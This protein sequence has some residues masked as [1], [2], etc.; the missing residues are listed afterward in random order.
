MAFDNLLIPMRPSDLQSPFGAFSS[1]DLAVRNVRTAIFL[2]AP[3][4]DD[5]VW[6]TRSRPLVDVCRHDQ[7][8]RQAVRAF[9]LSQIWTIRRTVSVMSMPQLVGCNAAAGA[10]RAEGPRALSVVSR[11]DY[12]WNGRLNT[13]DL[14]ARRQFFARNKRLLRIESNSF[15]VPNDRQPNTREGKANKCLRSRQR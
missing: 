7:R 13:P 12:E 11:K 1:L 3:V 15:D 5:G 14:G 6:H 2:T 4:T 9:S 10:A 8:L